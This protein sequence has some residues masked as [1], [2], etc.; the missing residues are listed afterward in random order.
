[1]IFTQMYHAEAF[2]EIFQVSVATMAIVIS[3]YT[4]Q[5][6]DRVPLSRWQTLVLREP[7]LEVTIIKVLDI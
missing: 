5:L 4:P 1:M 7:L 2:P 3:M 6:F